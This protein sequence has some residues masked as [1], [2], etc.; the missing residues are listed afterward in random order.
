MSN[1]IETR[2]FRE[3]SNASEGNWRVR[4]DRDNSTIGVQVSSV[5]DRQ[6]M[7]VRVLIP[8]TTDK[9]NMV[10]AD[11]RLNGRQARTLYETLDRY[12]RCYT[13]TY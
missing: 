8:F 3:I 5:G 2:S 1:K 9:G 13:D 4:T 12:Y 10:P 6:A 11:L 7:D